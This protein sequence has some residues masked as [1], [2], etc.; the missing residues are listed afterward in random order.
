MIPP[1]DIERAADRI[2]SLVRKTPV[3]EAPTL[4][5][6]VWLKCENQ[7]VTGSFKIR[8][9]TN[10]LLVLPPEQRARGVVTASS[11]NH[12]LGVARAARQLGI[13]A[14]V[15]VPTTA[16][17]SKVDAIRQLGATVDRV[18]DDCV[19]TEAYA[20]MLA[21]KTERA[22]ISP[23]N[24]PSIVAGQGTIG[25]ELIQ[26]IPNLDA[27][28]IAIGGGGLI[29]GVGSYLKAKAPH[30]E[31]IGCSPAA[32]PAM[33]RCLEAGRIIDVPCRD[34][35]SG[36][37]AGGVEPGSITFELCQGVVDRSIVVGEAEIA[38]AMRTIIGTHHM[39]IEGAAGVAVAGFQSLAQEYEGKTTAVVL[40]GA[41][42]NT[43]T[44]VK[45][46]AHKS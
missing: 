45:V 11:G 6:G 30:I 36:A 38:N 7:Q 3:E 25:H 24:D 17:D 18:G 14:T 20:R 32:S 26:Q 15:F 1:I 37:T 35:L 10:A 9:A 41:N 12:G 39:L 16:D 46:L 2:G 40:C 4:G 34:T 29:A 21:E 13:P 33:H 31:V 22:F 23:Y 27:V 44:L 42:V 5:P 8:G 28:F 19:D 43:Q